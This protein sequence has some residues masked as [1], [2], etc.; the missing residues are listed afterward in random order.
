M[1]PRIERKGKFP[2]SQGFLVCTST[3]NVQLS[4]DLCGC[5]T[6]KFVWGRNV[7]YVKRQA[8]GKSCAVESL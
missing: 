8:E 7:D 2:V 5:K 1:N 6:T 4:A 3:Q